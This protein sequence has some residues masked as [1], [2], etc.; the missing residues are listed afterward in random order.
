[1]PVRTWIVD[2][3]VGIALSPIET[4]AVFRL[5][6]EPKVRGGIH[7]TREGPFPRYLVVGG[8]REIVI[9]P[10]RKLPKWILR[11]KRA[12]YQP[13]SH[14]AGEKPSTPHVIPVYRVYCGVPV[15]AD[16]VERIG[17]GVAPV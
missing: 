4:P 10:R 6:V 13:A 7:E 16:C 14:R 8:Q 5:P 12:N 3:P 9:F 11:E 17:L 2:G 1:M 15:G